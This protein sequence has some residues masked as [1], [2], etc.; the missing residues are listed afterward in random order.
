MDAPCKDCTER[1][2]KCH[3]QCEKYQTFVESKAAESEKRKA[4]VE[5]AK[6]RIAVKSA[7]VRRA[8]SKEYQNRGRKKNFGK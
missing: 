5:E 8:K 2:F 4:A 1:H 7:M 6:F 3:G